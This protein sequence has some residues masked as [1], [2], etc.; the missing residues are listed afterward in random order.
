MEALILSCST[1]GG[2]NAAAQAL[3]Q[4]FQAKGHQTTFFDPYSLKSNH[5]A[6]SIGNAYIKLV[7]TSPLLF[8]VIYKIGDQYAK[9]QNHISIP[10][11]VYLAQK[12]SANLLEAYLQNHDFD[13]I[14]TSHVFCGEILTQLKKR[15]LALPPIYFITTDYTC[16]PFDSE[17]KADYINIASSDLK[18]EFMHYSIPEEKLLTFGI[19]VRQEF[20]Q[21]TS[22]QEAK[23]ALSLD[24]EKQYILVSGGSIGVGDIYDTIEAL[25]K[26]I[27]SHKEYELLVLVGNNQHLYEHLQLKY[28]D[29]DHLHLILPTN[30]VPLYMK[31]SDVFISKP[32]GLS[33]TEACVS[34]IPFLIITP[35]PGC[36]EC[37]AQFFENHGAAIYVRDVQNELNK[38]LLAVLKKD[39]ADLMMEKQ[40][41]TINARAA[42]DL[43]EW[44]E[45]KARN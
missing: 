3:V 32:G 1:G 25:K 31:A 41:Q 12:K 11:P 7:Q 5:L 2:H 23:T 19:P 40:K 17:V 13:V 10:S 20:A 42:D 30:Q 29:F 18:E 43:V 38:A 37:N 36:E 45:K 21:S 35:I 33:S 14:L 4:A 34:Q 39:R 27:L 26:F 8:G 15:G 6:H 9:M 22:K 28:E 16:A 24:Q 44:I